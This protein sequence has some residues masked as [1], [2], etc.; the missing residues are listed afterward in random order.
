ML[1]Q[2]PL[3]D[4]VGTLARDPGVLEKVTCAVSEPG[5]LPPKEHDQSSSLSTGRS[6]PG[7]S[8]KWVVR[9][10]TECPVDED[11]LKVIVPTMGAELQHIEF[12]PF[13]GAGKLD[14]ETM[15]NIA[16]GSSHVIES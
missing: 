10:P 8:R 12:G 11:G 2:T 14:E 16:A 6:S 1:P 3:L 7:A 9:C 4:R 15:K 5:A 13:C